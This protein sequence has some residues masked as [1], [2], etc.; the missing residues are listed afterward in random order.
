MYKVNY[1]R[2]RKL[3]KKVIH[4][5]SEKDEPNLNIYEDYLSNQN[6]SDSIVIETFEHYKTKQM[7]CENAKCVE[8]FQYLIDSSVLAGKIE[9]FSHL[10]EFL[11]FLESN[12][13][14]HSNKKSKYFN[15]LNIAL[16]KH[17][18]SDLMVK[19]TKE[20]I[21]YS[22]FDTKDFRKVFNNKIINKIFENGGE[23]YTNEKTKICLKLS[24]HEKVKEYS[25]LNAEK[26]LSFTF[27]RNIK[28]VDEISKVENDEDS[29]T[30]K[31]SIHELQYV[32][33]QKYRPAIPYA[34]F[35]KDNIVYKNLYTPTK[36]LKCKIN[37]GKEPKTIFDL[38]FNL[39][40]NNKKYLEY[41]LNWLAYNF[42]YGEK[43]QVAIIL[44]GEQGTG[45]GIFS[46][47][48]MSKI[49]GRDNYSQINAASFSSK[50][51]L[52]SSFENKRFI[53]IDEVTHRTTKNNESLLKALITN[54]KIILKKEI[55]F[56][57]QCLLT[58]NNSKV[59]NLDD[60]DR[61]Y[62]VFSTG[63]S[64]TSTNFLGYGSYHSLKEKIDLE[65][66]Y[67]AK[68]LKSY[69][70][71]TS[72]A[73]RI[74]DTPEREKIINLSKAHVVDFHNAILN[75]DI[76]F[77]Q[78]FED[79]EPVFFAHLKSDISL[80]KRINRTYLSKAFYLLY[81][82]KLSTVMIMSMLKD[83]QQDGTNIYEKIEHSGNNHYI[84]PQGRNKF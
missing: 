3:I 76:S 52:T 42:N 6:I 33:N 46:D 19:K 40:G 47:N 27:C 75:L 13:L 65:L 20:K 39:V 17:N 35:K 36:Y 38:L 63:S 59:F 55:E 31:L 74:L 26:V 15:K 37:E 2:E 80:K 45:K 48:I 34:F 62:T 58:A 69:D 10:E 32:H 60:S 44:Y 71:D 57:A 70:V 67:F 5:V 12:S 18:K 61:R 23:I 50:Y 49:Y 14:I 28:I 73:N 79:K 51:E 25:K 84:Y 53:N 22:K 81:G 56:H 68:Y 41:F 83:L 7:N 77:F 30:F 11:K 1:S 29:N 21:D 24:K 72:L 16:Y 4:T 82:E 8:Y 78:K 54:K 9:L 43:P 66:V 64:L